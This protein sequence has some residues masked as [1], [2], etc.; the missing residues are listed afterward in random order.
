MLEESE[1]ENGKIEEKR[2][3]DNDYEGIHKNNKNIEEL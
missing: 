1:L 2:C 3:A